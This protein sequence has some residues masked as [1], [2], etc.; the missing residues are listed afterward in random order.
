MIDIHFKMNDIKKNYPTS[1]LRK[2]SRQKLL[3]TKR[4]T[5]L[6]WKPSVT[7]RDGID[8]TYEWFEQNLTTLRR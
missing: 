1:I 7:L 8:K 3:D 5:T 6:G 2:E 4:L